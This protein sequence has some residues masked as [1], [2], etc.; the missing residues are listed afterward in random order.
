MYAYILTLRLQ[1][2][3]SKVYTW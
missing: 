3:E 1:S 2:R